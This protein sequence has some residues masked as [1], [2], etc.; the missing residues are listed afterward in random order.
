MKLGK[1]DLKI[2]DNDGLEVDR[3]Q[4]QK[5]RRRD[6]EK[7]RAEAEP[8]PSRRQRFEAL[9]RRYNQTPAAVEGRIRQEFGRRKNVMTL[10][11]ALRVPPVGTPEYLAW[12]KERSAQ[13]RVAWDRVSS[14]ERN[15]CSEEERKA[16]EIA[17]WTKSNR[18]RK[19]A[20]RFFKEGDTEEK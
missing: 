7:E 16:R 15:R 10:R 5:Y 18:T 9:C 17:R 6:F 4:H 8:R 2:L 14:Q 13:A 12:R 3:P 1:N 20:R 19:E 11:E